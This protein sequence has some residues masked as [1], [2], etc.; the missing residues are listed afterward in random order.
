MATCLCVCWTYEHDLVPSYHCWRILEGALLNPRFPPGLERLIFGVCM[1]PLDSQGWP[2]GCSRSLTLGPQLY[3]IGRALHFSACCDDIYYHR[4]TATPTGTRVS[5][6][7]PFYTLHSRQWMIAVF[8]IPKFLYC[9]VSVPCPFKIGVSPSAA[10][11]SVLFTLPTY[12]A[13]GWNL[14]NTRSLL[15]CFGQSW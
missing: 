8:S 12:P 14:T 6:F 7:F 5:F 11:C 4:R 9:V 2:H 15:L 10:F 1:E 13:G 3:S